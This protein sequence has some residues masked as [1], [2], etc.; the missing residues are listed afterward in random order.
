MKSVKN[1]FPNPVL[2]AGRDDYVESCRFNTA[3]AEENITIDSEYIII[4]I[5]YTLICNGLKQLI[6]EGTAAVIISVK[7][8]AASYSRLFRFKKDETD[9]TLK[10]PKYSVIKKV[11]I[12][13]SI[14]AAT[15]INSFRCDGEFNDMYFGSQTF[16]IRKGDI[17]AREDSRMI[18]IDDSELEKPISSIFNINKNSDQ[19][20]FIVP[21]F[22]DEKINIYLKPKLYDQYYN[23]KDMN[24]GMLRRYIT[25]VVVYPV[26]V[27]AISKIC[28]Y[29]QNNSTE[30]NSDRRWFRAIE[31]K[32][33]KHGIKMDN[34]F[35][36]PTML[37]DKLLGNVAYEALRSLND[38]LESEMNNGE[39]QM[40][41]GVD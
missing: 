26:L 22:S 29:Y 21:D 35:D 9:M 10:I 14:I 16:E 8:S 11:E 36:S 34:Y 41:G 18:Y 19:E 12:G 33:E 32:A 15:A 31:H 4:P 24:G 2:A 40:M 30:V 6:D 23:F 20:D 37:A 1:E 5:T 28:N 13:G 17:L 38:M 25:G 39:S 27:E 3:F 7:S